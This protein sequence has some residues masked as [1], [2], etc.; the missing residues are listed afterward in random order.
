MLN[1]QI[2]RFVCLRVFPVF[3]FSLTPFIASAQDDPEY[4]LELGG[5][6]GMQA[7]Q[8]D[9]GGGVFKQ[10]QPM[11]TLV[12]KYK[13]TPRTAWSALLGFGK[14]KGA[15][16]NNKTWYP[17]WTANP[18]TFSTSLTTFDVRFEYN[19]WAYGTGR[20]YRGARPLA[21]FITMGLGLSFASA[22]ATPQSGD[23]FNEKPV[24]F[25][26]PL[27]LGVKYKVADRMNLTAEWTMHLT[28]SDRLDAVRDPYGIESSGLFKN[29]DCYSVLLV[30][31]TYDLWA[32]CKTCHNDRE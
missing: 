2:I 27:G 14:L 26:M 12:A 5:G 19:F 16:Q 15:S 21:P 23:S 10:L 7:Y 20:E 22:T 18:L 31:L 29:T 3:L 9:F 4:R 30:S 24:A 28:G 6:L 25:E 11:G 17:E 32:K 13:P 1:R 8:G